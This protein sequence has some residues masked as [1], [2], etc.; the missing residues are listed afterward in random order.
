[1]DLIRGVAL[2]NSGE[3]AQCMV[4]ER[5]R[6]RQENNADVSVHSGK[7]PLRGQRQKSTEKTAKDVELSQM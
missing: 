7:V 4:R 6:G 3:T 1:M 2:I 5:K